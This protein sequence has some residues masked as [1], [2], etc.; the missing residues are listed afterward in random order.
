MADS[1]N[2]RVLKYDA[3][4]ASGAD[5]AAVAGQMLLTTGIANFVDGRGV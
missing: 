3:P 4:S 1:A 2:N 5:A